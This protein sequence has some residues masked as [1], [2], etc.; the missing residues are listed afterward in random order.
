MT[1][2]VAGRGFGS[3]TADRP[4]L[5]W[6]ATKT[7][8]SRFGRLFDVRLNRRE[9]PMKD[10][11][12]LALGIVLAF[13]CLRGLISFARNV[14]ASQGIVY[15]WFGVVIS[16]IAIGLAVYVIFFVQP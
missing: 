5:S 13:L 14:R 4:N 12:K 1:E 6:F 16:F 8:K 11:G 10:Q 9:E 2:E 15:N 7:T 3:V